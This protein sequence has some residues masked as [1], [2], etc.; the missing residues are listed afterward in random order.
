MPNNVVRHSMA[1]YIETASCRSFWEI[2]A[3]LLLHILMFSFAFSSRQH[4]C[5][6]TSQLT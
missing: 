3:G 1:N 6:H 2:G 5:C 4:G